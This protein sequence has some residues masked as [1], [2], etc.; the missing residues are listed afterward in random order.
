MVE[1]G[2]GRGLI[3]KVEGEMPGSADVIV[4]KYIAQ[5]TGLQIAVEFRKA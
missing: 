2:S 5:E 4:K 3:F 1:G